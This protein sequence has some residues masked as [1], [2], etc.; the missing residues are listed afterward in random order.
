MR[1]KK[2][3]AECLRATGKINN[4]VNESRRFERTSK[5][6][7]QSCGA[8][9]VGDTLSTPLTRPMSEGRK[10]E[11]PKSAILKSIYYDLS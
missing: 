5:G 9:T 11:P 4:W 7:L 6:K 1:H 10:E 3:S 8:P 2:Q